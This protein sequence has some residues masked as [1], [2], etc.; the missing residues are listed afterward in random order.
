[1]VHSL[2]SRII[3]DYN[4]RPHCYAF[5]LN[6]LKRMQVRFRAKWF[7]CLHFLQYRHLQIFC[8]SRCMFC[9]M[10]FHRHRINR[11]FKC[12]VIVRQWR[13]CVRC[14]F[15]LKLL[16]LAPGIFCKRQKMQMQLNLQQCALPPVLIK[17]RRFVVLSI[18]HNIYFINE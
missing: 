1:M 10:N 15:F 7:V 13:L 14:I 6:I 17:S 4:G 5:L 8:I 12:F 16:P 11:W 9:I 18:F 3:H 2:S